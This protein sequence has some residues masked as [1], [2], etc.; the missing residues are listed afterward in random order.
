[1]R[2][3]SI[4]INRLAYGLSLLVITIFKM[5]RNMWH[6]SIGKKRSSLWHNQHLTGKITK[7]DVRKTKKVQE[8]L[9]G[10]SYDLDCWLAHLFKNK[11][12]GYSQLSKATSYFFFC[13]KRRK[14]GFLFE[15]LINELREKQFYGC[16]SVS[17]VFVSD[18]SFR[19]STRLRNKTFTP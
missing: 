2:N 14:K 6:V 16:H 7:F 5:Y 18:S 10:K 1:M 17:T 19:F 15:S 4:I 3:G 13:F 9:N 11:K 8:L 12:K